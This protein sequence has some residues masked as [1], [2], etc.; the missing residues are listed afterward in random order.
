M[1]VLELLD[2]IEEIIDNSS[3]FPLTGKNLVDTEEILQIIKEIRVEMPEEIRQALLIMDERQRIMSEAKT[4]HESII[5]EARIQAEALIENDDITEKA[6]ARADEIIEA[7]EKSATTLK[8]NTF[9]YIDD[10]LYTLQEKI[11]QMYEDYFNEM[12]SQI[13]NTFEQINSTIIQNRN[14]I[15]DM[16]YQTELEAR[17]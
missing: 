4:E 10:I 12:Y 15:K 8:L 5:R 1:R 14:E 2:E 13:H 16:S 11:T 6:R 17:Q 3:G 7:A 9:D